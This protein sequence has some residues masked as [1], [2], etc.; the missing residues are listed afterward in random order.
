MFR[1]CLFFRQDIYA[2]TY[3]VAKSGSWLSPVVVAPPEDLNQNV[4]LVTPG[5]H[6]EYTLY[7]GSVDNLRR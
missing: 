3:Y 7:S 4:H 1:F 6:R 2:V 5:S